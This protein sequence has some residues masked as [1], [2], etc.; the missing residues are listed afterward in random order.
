MAAAINGTHRWTTLRFLATLAPA[1]ILWMS[2]VV[3]LAYELYSRSR[4]IREVD[5]VNLREWLDESSI[6]GKTLPSQVRELLELRDSNEETALYFKR[7][8]IQVHLAALAEPLQTFPT[9]LPMFPRLSRLEVRIPPE[10]CSEPPEQV[11]EVL[12]WQPYPTSDQSRSYGPEPNRLEYP[13]VADAEGQGI[14]WVR[15]DYHLHLYLYAQQAAELERRADLLFAGLLLAGALA[16]GVWG[17]RSWRRERRQELREVRAERQRQTLEQQVLRESLEKSEAIQR[18]V[19]LERAAAE[20]KSQIFAGI[21]ILAGSYAHNIK[22]LLVRPNDLIDRCLQGDGLPLPQRER[23]REVRETLDTVIERLQQ[24]LRTV[25]RDPSRTEATRL[26]LNE[27]LSELQRTW[28]DMARE[29]WR[30]HLHT[31]PAAVPLWIEGD[32]SHLQ[33]TI[34]NLL[35][36][37]RDA[38]F[39][40]RNFKRDQA[41]NLKDPEARRQAI[42]DAAAWKG[43]VTV[44]TLLQDGWAVLEVRD[45]GIGMSEDVRRECIKT[46]FSTKRDNA[47]YAG[48]N[49]GSGLGLS[50]VTVVLEHHRAKLEIESEPLRGA[51]FRVKFPPARGDN[52]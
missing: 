50:F 48:L 32:P 1:V 38:I 41:Y 6:A 4:W 45:D 37:A 33:Q 13:I 46:H 24:I 7:E 9:Q 20:M 3:W 21:G 12:T 51:L 16:M 2:L 26:D 31:Q 14:A 30:L 15:C 39:E 44:R 34:E 23:L 40:M 19:E 27:F 52:G 36:N 5:Q 28:T 43:T 8:E 10:P 17:Y 29:K 11:A 22:N 42:L 49:A 47:L 18:R 35:F 25:R